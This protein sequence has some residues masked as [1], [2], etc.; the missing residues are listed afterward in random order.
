[1]RLWISFPALAGQQ[2]GLQ[3]LYSLLFGYLNQSK[4]MLPISWPDRLSVFLSIWKSPRHC[5]LFKCLCKQGCYMGYVASHVLWLG[6]LAIE[7][8]GCIQQ[9]G[10]LH[11]IFFA[12]AE[13]KN[14]LQVLKALCLWFWLKP[15]CFPN[16][17]TKMVHW[18]YSADYQFCPPDYA[19]HHCWAVQLPSASNWAFWLRR[20]R[21]YIQQQVRLWLS[22]PGWSVSDQTPGL[23][24]SSLFE[25]PN[26]ADF[27]PIKFSSQIVLPSW[28]YK[29]MKLLV[30]TT[31]WALQRWTWFAII[32]VLVVTSSC[33]TSSS[34]SDSQ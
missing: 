12:W 31:T 11:V 2:N 6:S 5:F 9:C 21:S 30:G 29:W 22:S 24:K 13:W 16:S 20:T 4:T 1:M 18:L 8:E 17:L 3:G 10:E 26:Q 19:L 7:T 28:L 32:Q 25:D 34:Q 27:G 23:A 14:Q 15:I 33:P